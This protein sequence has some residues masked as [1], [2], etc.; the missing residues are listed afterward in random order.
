MGENTLE[1]KD[2][3]VTVIIATAARAERAQS[4][5]RAISG[6][7]AQCPSAKLIVVANGERC[8]HALVARLESDPTLHL[9][10]LEE[11]S[12][13]AAQRAGRQ[14]VHTPYF[15]FLDDDDE[16]LEGSIALRL[17]RANKSDAPD[18]VVGNG[19]RRLCDADT[20][21]CDLL[22]HSG[23]DLML[24]LLDRNWFASASALF[25]TSTVTSEYFDGK[26]KYFEWT[27]LAFRLLNAGRRFVFTSHRGFRLHDSPISLSKHPSASLS[28]PAFLEQ[29]LTI[30]RNDQVKRALRSRLAHAHHD[31]AD[32]LRLRGDYRSAWQHHIRSLTLPGGM[33]YVAYTRLF[34][35]MMCTRRRCRDSW[36]RQTRQ[37]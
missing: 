15:C 36:A 1:N 8:D 27:L 26:T 16:L 19:V 3:E 12:Y 13:P 31:C 25:R 7:Q 29:L 30:T 9:I 21:Y 32:L 5:L 23:A 34:I 17:Q 33:H 11:G 14:L 18:V 6:V 20:D 22:P 4:L 24:S 37:H 10:R 2:A 35:S 28:A